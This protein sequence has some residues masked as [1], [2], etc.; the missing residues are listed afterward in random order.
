MKALDKNKTW[1]LVE[2][3]VGK[4]LVECKWVYV[5]KHR[6]DDSIETQDKVGS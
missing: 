2:V 6:A 1:E 3:P 4:N 5:V